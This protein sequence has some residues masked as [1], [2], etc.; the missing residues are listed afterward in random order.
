M[1]SYLPIAPAGTV[2]AINGLD[3]V[4]HAPGRSGCRCQRGTRWAGCR[5]ALLQI[6]GVGQVIL[7]A[8][9]RDELAAAPADIRRTLVVLTQP[10]SS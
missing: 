8:D 5:S 4:A 3:E 1:A 2:I 10:T 9:Y 6:S 7:A